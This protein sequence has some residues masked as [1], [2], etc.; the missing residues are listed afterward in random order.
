[1]K[2]ACGNDDEEKLDVNDPK[3]VRCQRDV[4]LQ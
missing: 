4:C 1:M 3:P 2:D